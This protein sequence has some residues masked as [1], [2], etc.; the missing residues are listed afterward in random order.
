MLAKEEEVREHKK[1]IAGA[2]FNYGRFFL[3]LEKEIYQ[4]LGEPDR[5]GFRTAF[6]QFLQDKLNE[7]IEDCSNTV[8]LE[9]I[10][11]HLEDTHPKTQ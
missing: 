11:Q 9:K 7:E 2:V 5:P 4:V 10:E 3:D 6:R 1:A 8:T